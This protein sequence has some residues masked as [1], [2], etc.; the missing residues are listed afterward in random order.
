VHHRHSEQRHDRI[1]DE[2]LDRAAVRLDDPLHPLEVPREE[3]TQS[4]RI[5]RL[6]ERG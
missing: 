2:L 6:A 3:R 5:T 1:A 4:L